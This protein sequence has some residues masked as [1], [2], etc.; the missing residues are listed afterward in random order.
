M[1]KDEETLLLKKI[2]NLDAFY[3]T[4]MISFKETLL[5]NN[6]NL[7]IYMNM[8]NCQLEIAQYNRFQFISKFG[9]NLP[10]N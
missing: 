5:L 4:S 10:L 3:H 2:T 8:Y 6:F 9:Q 7:K 1:N